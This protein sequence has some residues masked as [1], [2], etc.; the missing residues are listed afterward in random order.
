MR[1]ASHSFVKLHKFKHSEKEKHGTKPLIEPK[2]DV[3]KNRSS[4]EFFSAIIKKGRKNPAE[5]R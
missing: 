5:G 3:K 2:T 1:E 4:Q